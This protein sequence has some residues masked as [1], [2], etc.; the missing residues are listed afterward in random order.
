MNENFNSE[1]WPIKKFCKKN[2]FKSTR[3]ENPQR[4]TQRRFFV[5]ANTRELFCS[6]KWQI[7]HNEKHLP[8]SHLVLVGEPL[9]PAQL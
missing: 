8:L 4:Q 9:I 1:K 6:V 3:P 7:V 5:E 2:S